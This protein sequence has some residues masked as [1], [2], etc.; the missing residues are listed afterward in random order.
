MKNL[1]QKGKQNLFVIPYFFTFANAVFGLFS[2]IKTLDGDFIGAAYCIMLAGVMD[3]FDGKLARAFG[4]TSCLGMELDS[5]CDAVSFCFAPAILLYSWYFHNLGAL[6]L[7]SV[8]LYLCFG[9]L[10]LAK[11]NIASATKTQN[12]NYFIGLPTTVAAFLVSQLVIHFTWV[13]Q[14]ILPFLRNPIWLGLFVL[15]LAF[16]MISSVH[17]VSFKKINPKLSVVAGSLL[18]IVC[19]AGF[20]YGLPLLFIGIFSYILSSVVYFVGYKVYKSLSEN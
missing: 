1:K 4:S 17:F 6:G 16:L 11:F 20:L 2:V 9:L 19:A 3:L 10:R 18:V 5:L 15:G 14:N 7:I 13:S 12:I 8:S